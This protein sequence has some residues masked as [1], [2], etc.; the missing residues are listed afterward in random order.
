M[1]SG[2]WDLLTDVVQYIRDRVYATGFFIRPL[3][4][5]ASLR[6]AE[7]DHRRSFTALFGSCPI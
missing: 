1:K 6:W 4:S 3:L 7:I 5:P 2:S